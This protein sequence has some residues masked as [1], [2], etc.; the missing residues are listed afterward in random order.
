MISNTPLN[1][2]V[3]ACKIAYVL[4]IDN[5]ER[6]LGCRGVDRSLTACTTGLKSNWLLDLRQIDV[7]SVFAGEDG[8]DLSLRLHS[9]VTVTHFSL[10]K[11]I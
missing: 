8:L 11:F 3:R 5:L 1:L 2:I 10:I 6:V 9:G 4:Y 7:V